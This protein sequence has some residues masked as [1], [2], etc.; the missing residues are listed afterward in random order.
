MNINSIIA[1]TDF[2]VAGNAALDRAAQLAAVH[3]T[4]LKLMSLPDPSDQSRSSA[5]VCLAHSARQLAQRHELSARPVT[6]VAKS[7][8]HLAE[9]A[10]STDLLVLAHERAFSISSMFLGR[11]PERLLRLCRCPVLVIKNV[12]R[13]PYSRILVAV[14]FTPESRTL[15]RLASGID[16][17]ADVALFHAQDTQIEARLRSANVSPEIIE[18]YRDRCIRE[19]RADMI[20]FIDSFEAGSHRVLHAIGRGDPGRQTAVQQLHDGA[21]LVVV[22]K[23]RRSALSDLMLGSIAAEA[24][25]AAAS[26]VLVVPHDFLSAGR[27]ALHRGAAAARDVALLPARGSAS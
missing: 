25:R 20:Q 13:E 8:T 27:V 24:L 22:G 6:Q 23:R 12:P 26:D 21:D 5:A 14:D 10:A 17:A 15:A 1:I 7:V 4:T 18:R 19:A 9:E 11:L 2:S 3:R 16:A